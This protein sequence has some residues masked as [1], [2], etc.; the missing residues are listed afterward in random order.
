MRDLFDELGFLNELKGDRI[1]KLLVSPEALEA[2]V[3]LSELFI[4]DNMGVD[5]VK[6]LIA[7][8]EVAV[9]KMEKKT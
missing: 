2:R 5:Q 9:F 8:L 4:E 7:S 1:K 6:Q 3:G